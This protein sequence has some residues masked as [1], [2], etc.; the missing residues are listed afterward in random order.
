MEREQLAG[1]RSGLLAGRKGGLM[2]GSS[3]GLTPEV[4]HGGLCVCVLGALDERV[5]G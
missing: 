1:W 2:K 3:E 5:M 4:S